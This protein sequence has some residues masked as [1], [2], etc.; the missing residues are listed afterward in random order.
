MTGPGHRGATLIADRAIR[1]IAQ[2]AATEALAPGKVEVVDASASVEGGRAHL[3]VSVAL[4]YPTALEETSARVRRHVSERTSQLT[5]LPVAE[6]DLR[7]S[8]LVRHP[9]PARPTARSTTEPEDTTGPV[10]TVGPH[11]PGEATGSD[12]STDTP[13]ADSSGNAANPLPPP[14]APLPSNAPPHSANTPNS[15]DSADTA[16]IADAAHPTSAAN[17]TPAPPTP[18]STTKNPAN[19]AVGTTE[20]PGSANSPDA[21]STSAGK[22]PPHNGESWRPW[23]RRR[24]PVAALALLGAMGGAVLLADVVSVHAGSH[25]P[26]SWRMELVSWLSRH[27]PGDPVVVAGG[28]TATV[29]SL[30]LLWLACT[31]GRRSLLP[32]LPP[33]GSTRVVLERTA[34]AA[35]VRDAAVGI[36]GVSRVVVRCG[37]RRLRVRARIAFGEPSGADEAILAAAQEALRGCGPSRPPQLRVTVRPEPHWRP[38]GDTP[39]PGGSLSLPQTTPVARQGGERTTA[40]RERAE[41]TGHLPEVTRSDAEPVPGGPGP[42]GREG[43]DD[44]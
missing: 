43:G 4:P 12:R 28:A 25:S 14:K 19:C 42:F 13:N 1:R 26:A 33:D 3:S 36:E 39:A 27:G 44:L 6:A 29:V 9:S 8:R 31:P 21:A 24:L 10:A 41:E 18:T 7:I 32:A 35:L 2:R 17:A 5:G 38:P 30:W 40:A 20:T 11:R 16:N 23:S 37:R 22:A 15:M 34:V